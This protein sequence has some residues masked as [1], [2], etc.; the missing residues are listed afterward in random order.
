VA[1]ASTGSLASTV[2][3]N[4][5]SGVSQQPPTLRLVSNSE[6]Q[7]N[8][9]PSVVTGLNKRPP[10]E[11]VAK[12]ADLTTP[13]G[14]GYLI[15]KDDSY[16]YLVLISDD[17][18]KVT[19]LMGNVQTVTFP[20][21]K[22]YLTQASNATTSFRFATVGDTTFIL[23]RDVT[24]VV[25]NFGEVGT[26][27]FSYTTVADDAAMNALS[28]TPN[29]V[30]FNTA[31]DKFYQYRTTPASPGV[32]TWLYQGYSTNGNYGPI[33]NTN[34]DALVPA[35]FALV[36]A[37]PAT[38]VNGSKYAVKY[39]FGTRNG[40]CLSYNSK[41]DCI[42]YEKEYSYSYKGYIGSVTA[43]TPASSGWVAMQG[44]E[45]SRVV[46]GRLDPSFMGTIYITQSIGNIVYSAYYNNLLI[47]SFTSNNGSSA[48]LSVQGTDV[49]A[50]GLR[51]NIVTTVTATPSLLPV[52]YTIERIGS[53]ISLNG[54]DA[55]GVLQVTATNG[56][57]AI[58]AYTTTIDSFSNLP[59]NEK[60]GRI[61]KV[62]GDVKDNGD[63]YYVLFNSQ[64]LWEETWGWNAGSRPINTT[65]PHTLLRNSD[66]TWVFSPHD[67]DAR[68]AG[69]ANSNPNPSFIGAAIHDMFFYGD[70]LTFLA[71]ENTILSETN[72][73][74]NF[75]RTSIAALVDSD[76]I[77]LAVLSST[78]DVLWHGI[79]YNDDLLLMSDR[80]QHRFAY[81]NFLGPKNIQIKYTTSFNVSRDIR[82]VNM[83][84][85]IYFVDDKD[86]Y[87]N[88]KIWEYFPQAN[89][90]GD[91]A[92]DVTGPIPTYIP[93]GVTCFAASPR[94]KA[95][96]VLS[97]TTPTSLYVYRYYWGA[98]AKVQNAWGT[99][100]FP[101]VTKIIWCGFNFNYLYMLVQRP[102]GYY[103]ERIKFEETVSRTDNVN[104]FMIDR[105]AAPTATSYD[106]ATKTT[107]I[108]LPWANT[109]GEVEVCSIRQNALI[110]PED[111]YVDLRHTVTVVSPTQV[112]VD[113]DLSD[114]NLIRVGIK[115]TMSYTFSTPYMRQTKGQGEVVVLDTL[116]LQLKYLSVYADTTAS[117]KITVQYPG[118]PD[119]TQ[120]FEHFRADDETSK[121]GG[122]HVR[123][124]KDRM[125]IQGH[126]EDATVILSNDTPFN[127]QFTAAEWQFVANLRAKTRL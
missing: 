65:M 108:T 24:P 124:W 77:D 69:D 109:N 41:G 71:D 60:I 34:A 20:L 30:V 120:E 90:T 113:G 73:F 50:E 25:D 39:V 93:S 92:D 15:D 110:R 28:P 86:D 95:A 2:L 4:L 33:N 7:I 99:W 52:G 103:I 116:R 17:D 43:G 121:I 37:L 9:W 48:A 91:D 96:V 89:Q 23:N 14:V 97:S 70:R 38:I 123:G 64:N 112:R 31:K 62:K 29:Q 61:V 56:D 101:D 63:D 100:T 1:R 35:G 125:A 76:P 78:V 79:P 26:Y 83:G 81:Q 11:H 74:E 10:V 94:T 72:S 122:D 80:T 36:S 6:E 5:V 84:G 88:A 54:L 114:A 119:R 8:A 27:A 19:D 107:L 40:R 105:N 22:A 49:I 68:Q 111:N 118:R 115:Y 46:V 127:A 45:L 18:L 16:Q 59:P 47:G 117:Y 21:G 32:S 82:P 66:G 67:W 104:Q 12:I 106:P 87:Q 51:A 75:Y 3:P 53:T 57:K 13:T 102:S 42:N 55:T 58:R 85:S 44:S 98:Q 126:N